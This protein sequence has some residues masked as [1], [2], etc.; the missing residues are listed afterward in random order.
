MAAADAK[1]NVEPDQVLTDAEG[2][3]K[4]PPK[5]DCLDYN[6]ENNPECYKNMMWAR[7]HSS[8]D[9]TNYPPGSKT[10]A[11]F[12]CALY[13]K[14]D[15]TDKG[16]QPGPH[17]NCSHAPCSGMSAPILQT[18]GTS[19]TLGTVYCIKEEDGE[20][21]WPA[22]SVKDGSG[23]SDEYPCSCQG[24][25][26]HICEP[27]Q[28]CWPGPFFCNAAAHHKEFTAIHETEHEHPS[29]AG[30]PVWP[31]VF[32]ALGTAFAITG[33]VVAGMK[34]MSA[35]KAPAKKKRAVRMP[36]CSSPPKE[37]P[38]P[39]AA[40]ATEIVYMPVMTQAAPV[41]MYQVAGSIQAPMLQYAAP[42]IQYAGP[43]VP[44]Q[45]AAP[46]AVMRAGI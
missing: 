11:D 39:P 28:Y 6:E 15:V 12:Q 40:P 13:L 21:V 26:A 36:L 31:W 23:L 24:D 30:A 33:A 18:G 17:W 20:P 37:A 1:E 34:Y 27:A 5:A 42:S 22:C 46:P 8:A 3:G 41:P 35:R 4:Y 25:A 38:A 43:A 44:M 10:I 29:A 45:Y 14:G 2:A 9:P 7:N 16:N 19:G 32:I